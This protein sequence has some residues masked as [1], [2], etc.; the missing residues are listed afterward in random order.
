MH[1]FFYFSYLILSHE[2]ST[3]FKSEIQIVVENNPSY[4]ILVVSIQN[5]VTCDKNSGT[6]YN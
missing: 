5:K 3:N 2:S 6:N 4:P 1:I